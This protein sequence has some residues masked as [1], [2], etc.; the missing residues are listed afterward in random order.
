[1]IVTEEE[2]KTKRCQEG[3]AAAT[4]ISADGRPVM[5]PASAGPVHPH[6]AAGYYAVSHGGAPMNCLGSGCMAWRW[7]QKPN[8]DFSV[9]NIE[10]PAW[11][12]TDRGYCGKAGG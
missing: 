1:M 4:G 8:F 5:Q 9:H 10:A 6:G 7:A 11:L 3:F 12:D 2:A